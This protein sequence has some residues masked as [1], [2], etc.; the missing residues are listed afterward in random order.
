MEKLRDYLTKDGWKRDWERTKGD[1]TR[2]KNSEITK[3]V[4]RFAIML[5]ALPTTMDAGQEAFEVHKG[6]RH[7]EAGEGL[8]MGYILGPI[9][10]AS[11][12]LFAVA[13]LYMGDIIK[14]PLQ[15]IAFPLAVTSVVTN[16]VSAR[17]EH[18]K[19]DRLVREHDSLQAKVD[20]DGD[21]GTS[22]AN[23]ALAGESD[24]VL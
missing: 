12:N 8:C 6:G 9:V 17:H 3:D 18:N 21:L 16:L 24:I 11:L 7:E 5:Y 14:E 15:L 22:V 23:G 10:G 4:G 20:V 13:A 19:F 2:L 1:L